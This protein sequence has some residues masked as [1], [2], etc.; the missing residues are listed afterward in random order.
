MS[1]RY[2]TPR[3]AEVYLWRALYRATLVVSSA[4]HIQSFLTHLTA[5]SAFTIF[6]HHSNSYPRLPAVSII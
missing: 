6:I 4:S 3:L 2:N 5:E 1:A